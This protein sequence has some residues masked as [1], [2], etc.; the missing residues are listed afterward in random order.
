VIVHSVSVLSELIVQSGELLEEAK[1][2][3]HFPAAPHVLQRPSGRVAL[4]DHEV[5]R[6]DG[7]TPGIA[8]E[9]VYEDKTTAHGERALNVVCALLEKLRNVGVRHILAKEALVTDTTLG[10][11]GRVNPDVLFRTVENMSHA[12]VQQVANIFN[13]VP[14]AAD[15]AGEDLIAVALGPLPLG[16]VHL[17]WHS[18]H[19]P[20]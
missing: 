19:H 12:E 7:R 2:G 4:L 15:D 8:H 16:V 1:V 5:C 6:N 13:G 17:P 20:G 9:A 18:W 14:A 3:L 11:L 10:E